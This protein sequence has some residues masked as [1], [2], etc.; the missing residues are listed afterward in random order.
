MTQTQPDAIV[1]QAGSVDIITDHPRK[2]TNDYDNLIAATKLCI[3]DL[4]TIFI[5]GIPLRRNIIHQSRALSVNAHLRD[6]AK[7]D[8][9]I[10]FISNDNIHDSHIGRDGIHLTDEGTQLLANNIQNTLESWIHAQDGIHFVS[11]DYDQDF[12]QLIPTILSR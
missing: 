4:T 5:S 12:P 9:R 6:L 11:Q 3:S 10:H 8:H 1:L 7:R 2:V